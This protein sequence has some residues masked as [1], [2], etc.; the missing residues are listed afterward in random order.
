VSRAA[1][2]FARSLAA[3]AVA[4]GVLAAPAAAADPVPVPRV[5]AVVAAFP[6][7]PVLALGEFH[8]WT[9]E[10]GVIRRVVAD[11]RRTSS[12]PTHR[13]SSAITWTLSSTS[14]E[15]GPQARCI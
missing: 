5:D 7:R 13:A 12:G 2:L 6:Q 15:T 8:G 4:A 1:L 9:Q 10:H 3:T 14:V 11:R